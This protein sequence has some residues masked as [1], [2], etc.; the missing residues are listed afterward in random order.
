[1][2]RLAYLLAAAA[3]LLCAVLAPAFLGHYW[4]RVVTHVFMFA[5]LAEGTNVIV[6]FCGYP[7]LGNVVF[8]GV[9][10]Y[11]A[12]ILMSR[13]AVPFPVALAAAAG[14]AFAY[15]M[16][17]G[18]PLLRLRGHYF[19]I[20]TLGVNEGTRQV[21]DNLYDLT[22]GAS[23]LTL[24][25]MQV[26]VGAIYHFFYYVMLAVLV[27]AVLVSVWLS[28]SR[29]GYG[30]RAIRNDED[31]AAVMG[32]NTTWFK[33]AAWAISAIFVGLAGGVYAYW[34]SYIEPADVFDITIAVRFFIMILLG[35][36]GTVFGPIVGAVLLELTS[37]TLWSAFLTYHTALLGLVIILVVVFLPRGLPGLVHKWPSRWAWLRSGRV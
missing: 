30:L 23:G 26:S 22:G 32:I 34:N 4:L 15:A 9:G 21:M 33:M 28:R 19:A 24:P 31:A 10:A 14:A 29:F 7:A 35:G 18:W 1:M 6:G 37:E 11:A 2:T 17:L 25:I 20:A 8:F 3:V 16:I 36:A 5:I 12:G 27:C 13:T